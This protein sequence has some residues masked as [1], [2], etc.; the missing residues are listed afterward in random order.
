MIYVV[1]GCWTA[2]IVYWIASSFSQKQSEQ[3]P[4]TLFR[5]IAQFLFGFSFFIMIRPD[6]LHIPKIALTDSASAGIAGVF[7]CILGLFIC[8]WARRTI[9]GNWSNSI[10]FKKGHELVTSGPY[11]YV[12]HPIYSGYL[13]MFL[14]TALVVGS[15]GAFIGLVSLL[16]GTVMRIIQEERLMTGH[17]KQEY[18]EYRNR[19]K[20]LVPCLI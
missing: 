10:D 4:V 9:A 20:A 8:I 18:S 3:R 12:R 7:L 2:F 6:L 19:T 11:S 15:L 13:T 17:F 14:G 5:A 16:L 1:V